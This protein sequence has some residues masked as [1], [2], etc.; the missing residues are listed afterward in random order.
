VASTSASKS[1]VQNITVTV[2]SGGTG[3]TVQATATFVQIGTTT[4]VTV[5]GGNATSTGICVASGGS[6]LIE[7]SSVLAQNVDVKVNG[8]TAALQGDTLTPG[9]GNLDAGQ[10]PAS[11]TPL[12]NGPAGNVGYYGDITGLFSGTPLGSTAHSSGGNTFGTSGSPF[13]LDTSA[14]ATPNPGASQTW[15]VNFHFGTG[16]DT[17]TLMAATNQQFITGFVDMGGPPGGNSFDPTGQVWVS[18]GPSF[19]PGR[20]RMCK[21]RPELFLPGNAL[22]TGPVPS[23][24]PA[25]GIQLPCRDASFPHE[26]GLL[27]A[28]FF[29]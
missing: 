25:R 16:S 21:S 15:N 20:S 18:P 12:P 1:Q 4:G 17:L 2:P 22:A 6:A 28:A 23:P 8:G 14:T 3:I 26:A 29:G 5:N 7:Q 11:A 10:L 24:F 19:R 27:P 9:S 13:T